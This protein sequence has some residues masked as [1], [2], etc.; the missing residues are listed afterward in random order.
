MPRYHFHLVSN[1]AQ[2]LDREGVRLAD[3]WAAQREA[4]L[5]A[6]E[7][8]KPGLPAQHRKWHGWSVQVV[9]EQG[10]EVLFVPVV[11]LLAAPWAGR[12]DKRAS[13]PGWSTDD[14]DRTDGIAHIESRRM[15][16][17]AEQHAQRC[18]QLQRAI[19]AQI[20]LAK[21]SARRS[22]QLV[23]QWRTLAAANPSR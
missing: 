5:V 22:A 11:E 18:K 12:R 7:L 10:G 2:V 8:V 9:D 16:V 1:C 23:E 4:F 13:T 14:R 17:Q 15:T 20:E 19:T 3:P 21:E 6:E